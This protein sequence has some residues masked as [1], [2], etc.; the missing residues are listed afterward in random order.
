MQEDSLAPSSDTYLSSVPNPL[1][2]FDYLFRIGPLV[3]EVKFIADNKKRGNAVELTDYYKIE[4]TKQYGESLNHIHTGFFGRNS[5]EAKYYLETVA[6]Q[7]YLLYQQ[8]MAPSKTKLS[9]ELV[10][11][12]KKVFFLI[13]ENFDRNYGVYFNATTVG[14]LKK[15]QPLAATQPPEMGHDFS[16][17]IHHKFKLKTISIDK[18]RNKANSLVGTFITKKDLEAFVSIF[19]PAVTDNHT[20]VKWLV[21]YNKKN[22]IKS[23]FYLIDQL[24]DKGIIERLTDE[25]FKDTIRLNFIKADGSEINSS[26]HQ[27]FNAF[28]KYERTLKRNDKIDNFVSELLKS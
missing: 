11:Y 6:H 18:F 10:E 7:M 5:V 28:K 20:K 1:H 25:Q 14:Y 26:I 19:N 17:P 21:V 24:Q 8:I 4:M 27:E 22:S 12:L 16:N 2:F 15:M 9:S 3:L 13:L 23:L